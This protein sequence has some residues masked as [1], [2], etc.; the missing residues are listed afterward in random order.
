MTWTV[1]LD[2]LLFGKKL[3]SSFVDF[4]FDKCMPFYGMKKRM[5]NSSCL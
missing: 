4:R 1:K 5:Q 2:D 3:N